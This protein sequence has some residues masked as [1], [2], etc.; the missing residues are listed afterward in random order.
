MWSNAIW[1]TSHGYGHGSHLAILTG[2]FLPKT[3]YFDQKLNILVFFK[4]TKKVK[5]PYQKSLMATMVALAAAGRVK[6]ALMLDNVFEILIP[7]WLHGN[8][9]FYYCIA[10]IRLLANF[11]GKW[12]KTPKFPIIWYRRNKKVSSNSAVTRYQHSCE[13]LLCVHRPLLI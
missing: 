13:C 7:T 5:N 10:I 11:F 2:F 9:I 3:E 12:I 8:L 6:T 1:H 4:W